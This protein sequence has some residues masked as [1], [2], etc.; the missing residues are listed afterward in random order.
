MHITLCIALET[1]QHMCIHTPYNKDFGVY[2]FSPH[3]PIP[4]LPIIFSTFVDTMMVFYQHTY[5]ASL[6][7][8]MMEHVVIANVTELE[9]P[10]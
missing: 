9:Q 4:L 5:N 3:P 6:A 10:M 7:N 1:I 2:V 8:Q